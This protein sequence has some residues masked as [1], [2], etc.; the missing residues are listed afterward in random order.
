[1]RIKINDYKQLTEE[2]R[3]EWH[4]KHSIVHHNM[5]QSSI[6][7][8]EF[9]D[10]QYMIIYDDCV[11]YKTGRKIDGVQM[12]DETCTYYAKD[13]KGYYNEDGTKI[14]NSINNVCNEHYRA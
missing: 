2:D 12:T 3:R 9:S 4:Y 13:G 6:D 7:T 1:M 14:G 8:S 10:D 5:W 11:V